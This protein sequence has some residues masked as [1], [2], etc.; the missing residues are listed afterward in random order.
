LKKLQ[1]VDLTWGILDFETSLKAM[2][3]LMDV[4]VAE[5]AE[6]KVKQ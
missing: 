4:L 2:R 5:V 3:A 6:T 1:V